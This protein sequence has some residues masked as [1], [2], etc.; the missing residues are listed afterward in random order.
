LFAT[1]SDKNN[2][3][4]GDLSKQKVHFSAKKNRTN[5]AFSVSNKGWSQRTLTAARLRAWSMITTFGKD[6]LMDSKIALEE[7]LRF[8]ERL[9]SSLAK[10]GLSARPSDFARAFNARADGAAVTVHAARKWLGGEAIPTHEK[11]V[12]LAVWLGVSAAWLRFGDQEA[13]V[14]TDEVIPES[15][16]STPSLA[17]MNDILSLPETAQKTIRSI[18]DAFLLNYGSSADEPGVESEARH[19]SQSARQ[20][21]GRRNGPDA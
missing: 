7:R 19:A 2:I 10:A 16:I 3:W 21:T 1:K 8:S 18:V 13:D 17:L 6:L 11:V 12:I 4:R 14:M 5:T 15:S 20:G 9:R